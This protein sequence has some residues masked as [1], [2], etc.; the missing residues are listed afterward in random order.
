MQSLAVTCIRY[1]GYEGVMTNKR[2]LVGG[3]VTVPSG[4]SSGK[5]PVGTGWS[6]PRPVLLI[7]LAG[8]SH[9]SAIGS[10]PSSGFL[11]VLFQS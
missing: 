1:N 9:S 8:L 7:W 2:H 10:L 3:K 6:L 4:G 5:F 11:T